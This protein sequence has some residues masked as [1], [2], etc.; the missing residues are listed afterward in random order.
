MLEVDALSDRDMLEV[1]LLLDGDMLE[2]EAVLDRLW[3]T[4]WLPAID[5]GSCGRGTW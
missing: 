1:E 2:V 5:R 3:N 4:W